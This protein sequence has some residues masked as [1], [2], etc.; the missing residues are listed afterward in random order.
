MDDKKQIEEMARTIRPILENRTDIGYIP[1]LDKPIA[2]ELIKHYQPKIPEGA[3]VLTGEEY[4]KM[5]SLYDCSQGAY[6]T[7]NI[8]E[9]PLTIEGLREAVDEITRLYNVQTELQELNAKYYNEAKDLRR[10][11]DQARKETVR[12]IICE[13]KAFIYDNDNLM[14]RLDIIAKQYGV[15]VE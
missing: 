10:K 14:E 2:K 5:K 1:D 15:E 6:M 7:S 12:E 11:L 3:V 4:E 13:I 8:G 9:L